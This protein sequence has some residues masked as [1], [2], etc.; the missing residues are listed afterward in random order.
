MEAVLAHE[1]GHAKL[2]HIPKSLHPFTTWRPLA[3]GN[4]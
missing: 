3:S 2:K 1:L 4:Y